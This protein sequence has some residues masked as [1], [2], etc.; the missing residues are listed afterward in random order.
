[1]ITGH[2]SPILV[3]FSILK[4]ESPYVAGDFI[5]AFFRVYFLLCSL[6]L[7]GQHEFLNHHPYAV[8]VVGCSDV[9]SGLSHRE[10][11]IFHGHAQAGILNH[12]Q[13]IVT[14]A[15][16]YHLLPFK[17]Q[18]LQQTGQR[19]GLV[20]SLW[21]DFQEIRLGTVHAE[22]TPHGGLY[23][24]LHGHQVIAV[25]QHQELGHPEIHIGLHILHLSQRQVVDIGLGN[26]VGTFL[27]VGD[28][29][30]AFICKD[31]YPVLLCQPD[32]LLIGLPGQQ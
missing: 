27:I 13:V 29:F 31:I 25:I 5:R 28:N 8:V 1:M 30:P 4:S 22:I 7:S 26:G 9:I 6:P 10:N 3:H 32:N 24:G 14:V 11:G 2:I 20:D 23:L 12:G 15:A 19:L 18:H 21:H 17:P 16:G